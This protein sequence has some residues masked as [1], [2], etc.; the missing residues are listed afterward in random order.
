MGFFSWK[1]CKCGKSI[2]AYPFAKKDKQRSKIVLVTPKNHRHYGVYDGYG[3]ITNEVTNKVADVLPTLAQEIFNIRDEDKA[4]AK[5]SSPIKTW[6]LKG[7]PV[8]ELDKFNYE[9]TI[10]PSEIT[11]FFDV[12]DKTV[13]FINENVIGNKMN[14]LKEYGFTRVTNFDRVMEKVK[15]VHQDCY[16][17]EDYINLDLS[18]SCEDQGFFYD[19]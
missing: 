19:N 1:C 18:K 10:L 11:V 14:N 7:K 12:P 3:H 16:H 15:I 4:R 6:Y 9:E 13:E 5:V 2:P 17:N 8:F